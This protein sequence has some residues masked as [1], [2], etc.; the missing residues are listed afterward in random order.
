MEPSND[1]MP[2]AGTNA[3][4]N[5]ATSVEKDNNSGGKV[6]EDDGISDYGRKRSHEDIGRSQQ[7]KEALAK[8]VRMMT[9]FNKY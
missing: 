1:G 4:T 8:H 7:E 5:A 3:A 6:N 9:K 2:Q